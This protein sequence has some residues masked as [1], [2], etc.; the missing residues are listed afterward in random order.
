ME[1]INITALAWSAQ[2][3]LVCAC[4][5]SVG[6]STEIIICIK[7]RL[8]F[9]SIYY[10]RGIISLDL[11]PISPW[12]GS[13]G[14][15]VS[16]IYITIIHKFTVRLVPVIPAL[17]YPCASCNFFNSSDTCTITMLP[18]HMYFSSPWNYVFIKQQSTLII[19]IVRTSA[20]PAPC[21]S[22]P[23][24]GCSVLFWFIGISISPQVVV[25]SS[26]S[27]IWHKS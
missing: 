15:Y 24:L 11:S 22:T 20:K 19:R 7:S 23:P 13:Y 10:C 8:S 4:A 1:S 12:D 5:Y 3:S 6:S 21:L 26:F 2:K 25:A 27:R 17:N 16:C 9:I 14:L 18:A